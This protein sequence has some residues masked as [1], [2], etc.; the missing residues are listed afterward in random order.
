MFDTY[1]K[2]TTVYAPEDR[3]NPPL[4]LQ[5]LEPR[6]LRI[7]Y[8]VIFSLFG[9]AISLCAFEEL[10]FQGSIGNIIIGVFLFSL[11]ISAYVVCL[12]IL[13]YM[14]RRSNGTH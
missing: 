2:T 6:Y 5:M 11:C 13:L 10:F 14:R 3:T 4:S 1:G 9:T 12:Q 8:S 7:F